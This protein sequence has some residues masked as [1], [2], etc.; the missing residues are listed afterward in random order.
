MYAF[1]AGLPTIVCAPL[2]LCLIELEPGE[3]LSGKA[4]IGD[5][6]RWDVQP[7]AYGT[8]SE[9]ITVLIVKAKAL[10]LDT[11]LIIPTDRRIYYLRLVSKEE[12]YLARV[13]F[14]Y[15]DDDTKK[16]ALFAANRKRDEELHEVRADILPAMITADEI[17]FNYT[18]TEKTGPTHFTPTRAYSHQGKMFIAMPPGME[19]RTAPALEVLGS[20]GKAEM[21]N[22]R[23]KTSATGT[24]YIVDRLFDHA[25]LVMGAGKKAQKVEI[26]R[27]P[28]Q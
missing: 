14:Q 11:N 18:I 28:G 26:S 25:Q 15:T 17:D 1:G 12:G 4:H 23:V 3:K 5:S 9:A 22:Y 19:H 6:V 7:E 27:V 10:S 20:D 2:R 16:W 24:A 21:T 13:G 8:G